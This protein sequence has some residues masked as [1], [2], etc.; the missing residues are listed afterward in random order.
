M[1]KQSDFGMDHLVM[2]MH[3]VVSCIVA[4]GCLLLTVCSLGK[5][6]SPCLPHFVLKGQICQL[7]QVSL[8]FLLLHSSA[9]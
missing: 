8:D 7:V 4:R 5:T 2:S 3:R 9:L 6:V 1:Y